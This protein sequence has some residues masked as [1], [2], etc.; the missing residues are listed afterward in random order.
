MRLSA[1]LTLTVL[2]CTAP[3]AA[4]QPSRSFSL[5]LAA[6]LARQQNAGYLKQGGEALTF[7]ASLPL[8]GHVGLRAD[9]GYTHFGMRGIVAY[10]PGGTIALAPQSAETGSFGLALTIHQRTHRGGFYLMAGPA[11]YY[12]FTHPDDPNTVHAGG[13]IGAGVDI[14][15]EAISLFAE[16][17][18][19]HVFGVPG[20]P[21]WTLPVVAGVKIGL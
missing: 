1:S 16:A 15:V 20:G 21:D 7:Q 8:S 3:L 5:G 2:V 17:E 6:G 14:P 10:S 19:N 11:V 18:Y 9:L 13:R 4:Q 12:L